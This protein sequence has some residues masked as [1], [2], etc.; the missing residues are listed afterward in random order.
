MGGLAS[1]Y[2]A[3]LSLVII[4]TG[5]LFVW[6]TR[7]VLVTHSHPDHL[8][9]AERVAS[10]HRAS[11]RRFPELADGDVVRA[12]NLNITVPAT[13]APRAQNA[14]GSTHTLDALDDRLFE[15][16]MY[17]DRISGASSTQAWMKSEM[18]TPMMRSR[19]MGVVICRWGS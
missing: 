3:G 19:R 11:V 5:L 12:G 18:M 9:L 13:G 4:G 10:K 14:Q 1:H 16:A 7:V 6:N 2:Y 17:K 8:P 15:S